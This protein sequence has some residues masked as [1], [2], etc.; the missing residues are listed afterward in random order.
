MCICTEYVCVHVYTYHR[1]LYTAGDFTGVQTF[2]VRKH[3]G[4]VVAGRTEAL[5][6]DTLR[7]V[8]AR[9]VYHNL[10]TEKKVDTNQ[11]QCN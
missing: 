9:P 6:E 2:F 10:H 1:S 3:C 5:G 7:V 11:I 4:G 8:E